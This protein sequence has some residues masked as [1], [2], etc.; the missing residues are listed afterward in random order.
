MRRRPLP[1]AGAALVRYPPGTS[2][3]S[4]A[5][6]VDLFVLPFQHPIEFWLS[7]AMATII[8]GI[9]FAAAKSPERRGIRWVRSVTSANAKVLFTVLFIVWAVF[10]GTLL[11]IVPHTGANSPYGGIALIA[12]FS[13]FFISMG[14]IWSVVGE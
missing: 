13:G 5:F 11:Q 3:P 2:D 1:S 10:F 8:I 9:A 6:S 4:E 14:L 7:V 12:L